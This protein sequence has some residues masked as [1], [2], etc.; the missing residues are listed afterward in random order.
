MFVDSRS[1]AQN[2]SKLPSQRSGHRPTKHRQYM[3]EQCKRKKTRTVD[4]PAVRRTRKVGGAVIIPE[5]RL[6]EMS[7]GCVEAARIPLDGMVVARH[8]AQDVVQQPTLGETWEEQGGVDE[9][10]PDGDRQRPV[11]DGGRVGEASEQ[12]S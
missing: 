3:P 1:G 12:R 5:L 10:V 11:G 7:A 4:R 6:Q 8:R 2:W 9:S